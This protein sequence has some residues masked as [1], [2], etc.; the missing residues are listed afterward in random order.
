[1]KPLRRKRIELTKH[2]GIQPGDSATPTSVYLDE[3]M[4]MRCL[5]LRRFAWCICRRY[6]LR[7]PLWCAS[8]VEEDRTLWV[9]KPLADGGRIR[10]GVALAM[11]RPAAFARCLLAGLAWS[12]SGRLRLAYVPM[13]AC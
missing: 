12:L 3:K 13:L 1:V 9:R 11:H 2:G 4:Q 10:G 8:P 5:E 7:S 6:A